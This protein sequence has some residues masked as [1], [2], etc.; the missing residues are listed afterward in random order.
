MDEAEQHAIIDSIIGPAYQEAMN[1]YFSLESEPDMPVELRMRM[2]DEN[3]AR[4]DTFGTVDPQRVK[5]MY[6]YMQTEYSVETVRDVQAVLKSG[7]VDERVIALMLAEN[8]VDLRLL[9]SVRQGYPGLDEQVKDG[10]RG[11]VELLDALPGHVA[12]QLTEYG[13]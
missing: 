7:A 2:L 13:F 3:I 4:G 12:T 8:C 11:I 10:E 1:R 9:A 5:G 6:S